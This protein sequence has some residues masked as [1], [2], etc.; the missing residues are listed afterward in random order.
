[1]L[2]K[3]YTCLLSIVLILDI[4]I[5]HN[6]AGVPNLHMIESVDDEKVISVS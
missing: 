3:S 1:M 4:T 6:A 5:V 2:D